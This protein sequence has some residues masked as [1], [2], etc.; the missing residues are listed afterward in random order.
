ML[1]YLADDPH[2]MLSAARSHS[3]LHQA[4]AVAL[5]SITVTPKHKQPQQQMNSMRLYLAK[6]G[7]HLVSFTL[8]SAPIKTWRELHELPGTL[9]RLESLT[10]CRLP[11]Q[12]QPGRSFQGV[13]H[14]VLLPSLKQLRLQDCRLLD[15]Q[16]ALAAALQQL[17]GLQHLSM[18]NTTQEPRPS[19]LGRS[20]LSSSTI[21]FPTEVL[22]VLQ[23]PT[24]LKLSRC[25]LPTPAD[26]QHLSVLTCLQ[27]LQ[28]QLPRGDI[29]ASMLSGLQRLTRLELELE[30]AQ[31]PEFD[32]ERRISLQPEA[33]AS[34]PE[35][36]HLV[37]V[38]CSIPD[39]A[40]GIAQLLSHLQPLQQ[41]THLDVTGTLNDPAAVAPA[42]TC[43]AL[44]A[45]S[46][47]Q[48]LRLCSSRV[49]T[50]C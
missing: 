33:L 41:L 13:L 44:T 39:G 34:M 14:A 8:G 10:L 1:E 27:H 7:K 40:A 17:P 38:S 28:L 50:A 18:T 45:S 25:T 15:G 31:I 2:S 24:Y 48:C 9:Q 4:A 32:Q 46:K 49:P 23:Q 30:T 20:K 19:L 47:L 35:L 22:E 42:A 43:A 37:L 16:L 6:H 3:R 36:Q 5:T 21:C 26:L 12:M 11:L 29:E